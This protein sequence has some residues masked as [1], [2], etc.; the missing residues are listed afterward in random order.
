MCSHDSHDELIRLADDWC[1]SSNDDPGVDHR[2]AACHRS[3]SLL[4]CV[5]KPSNHQRHHPLTVLRHTCTYR[6]LWTMKGDHSSPYRNQYIHT[7][8]KAALKRHPTLIVVRAG[9]TNVASVNKSKV[10]TLASTHEHTS[11]YLVIHLLA[12]TQQHQHVVALCDAHGVQI[13][14]DVSTRYPALRDRQGERGTAVM[15]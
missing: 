1:Y 5:T 14:E 3:P 15:S 6:Q 2:L 11:C 9:Y 10:N 8:V 4:R 12:D 7:H 13:T